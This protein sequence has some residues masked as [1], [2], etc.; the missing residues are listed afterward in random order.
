[1][2]VNIV[3]YADL[4]GQLRTDIEELRA[5]IKSFESDLKTYKSHVDLL[6]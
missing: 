1:M 3:M 4:E 2:K 5:K 6:K